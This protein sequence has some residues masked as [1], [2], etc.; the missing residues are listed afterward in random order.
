MKIS[1]K[2]LKK[3][4]KTKQNNDSKLEN[5]KQRKSKTVNK[6]RF[7]KITEKYKKYYEIFRYFLVFVVLF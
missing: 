5:W 2:T 3:K 7:P 1:R 6:I 4:R